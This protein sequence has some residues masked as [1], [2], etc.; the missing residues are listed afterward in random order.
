MIWLGQLSP[1]SL[2]VQSKKGMSRELI[3]FT[4]RYKGRKIEISLLK[5]A[6]LW[7]YK[8]L[9]AIQ[10]GKTYTLLSDWMKDYADQG[11]EDFDLFWFNKPMSQL[12]RFGLMAI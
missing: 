8:K 3:E 12:Y 6:G 2:R 4:I 11:L 1:Y 5:D 7:L 10:G 9:Y